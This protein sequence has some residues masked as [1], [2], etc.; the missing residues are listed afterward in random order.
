MAGQPRFGSQQ[1]NIGLLILGNSLMALGDLLATRKE[2]EAERREAETQQ[3][4]TL[5]AQDEDLTAGLMGDVAAAQ[6]PAQL[7]AIEGQAETRFPD[8]E[9]GQRTHMTDDGFALNLLPE[10]IGSVRARAEGRPERPGEIQRRSRMER[11]RGEIEGAVDARQGEFDEQRRAEVR[12]EVERRMA[13]L[14]TGESTP[15]EVE[16]GSPGLME[17]PETAAR[18]GRSAEQGRAATEQAERQ[19]RASLILSVLPEDIAGA[20]DAVRRVGIALE[21]Q[22]VAPL[23]EAERQVI[24]NTFE[25]ANRAVGGEFDFTDARNLANDYIRQS[26]TFVTRLDAVE[27]IK[28]ARENPGAVA[29]LD[30]VFA[31][32]KMLDPNS[33]IRESE[34]ASAENAAGVPERIR[35][36]FNRV[37]EGAKL[38][39]E[40][41]ED[42]LRQAESI[43]AT[44]QRQQEALMDRVRKQAQAGGIPEDVVIIDFEKAAAGG[45]A[46]SG[47]VEG[48]GS[49]PLA[50]APGEMSN[51]DI[52]SLLSDPNF[53]PEDEAL[54][55]D[56]ERR[57]LQRLRQAGGR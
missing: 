18:L 32:M 24:A 16:A 22:G 55:T 46:S 42:F 41:R 26:E 44:S 3:D 19:G 36:V 17:D 14:R 49:D 50:A 5:L 10:P 20:E 37:F 4:Q 13:A 29:D 33:V 11:A 39:L 27:R 9:I 47:R 31:F 6:S 28:K 30:I 56:G 43:F 8:I 1:P 21:G 15:E 53:G 34:Q 25:L 48:L 52:Q 57:R 2:K 23:S 38:G 51:A 12:A 35:N 54:L 40:Q 7:R 45:G